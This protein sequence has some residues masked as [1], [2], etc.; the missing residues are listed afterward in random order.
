MI[1]NNNINLDNNQEDQ[2]CFYINNDTPQINSLV[3]A[4]SCSKV[5]MHYTNNELFRF[6]N[7]NHYIIHIN[8]NLCLSLSKSNDIVLN[9][10]FYIINNFNSIRYILSCNLTF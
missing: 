1:I 6:D 4:Y 8:S 2:L 10:C 7:T 5:L 3:E 9:K